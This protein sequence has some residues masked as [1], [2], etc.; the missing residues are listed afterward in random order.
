MFEGTLRS[1]VCPL[2]PLH[3][4]IHV[5]R[6]AVTGSILLRRILPRLCR[7]SHDHR[8]QHRH[9]QR[10]C[11]RRH[12]SRVTISIARAFRLAAVAER[13]SPHSSWSRHRIDT[14]VALFL[15]NASR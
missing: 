4:D 9:G 6:L 11:C 14:D 8:L 7:P 1:T 3:V 15:V 2:A 12:C 5:V 10:Q 13:L